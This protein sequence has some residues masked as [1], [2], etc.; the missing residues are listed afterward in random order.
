MPSARHFLRMLRD[1][2]GP[3]TSALSE[4]PCDDG[5]VPFVVAPGSSSASDVVPLGLPKEILESE[6]VNTLK[7][8][9]FGSSDW[10]GMKD[11]IW[12]EHPLYWIAYKTDKGKQMPHVK[13]IG[14]V[15]GRGPFE[16]AITGSRWTRARFNDATELIVEDN[17]R[18]SRP[19]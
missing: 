16:D 9:D 6:I 19:R 18:V 7:N 15:A 17:Y 2:P 4:P 12:E 10:K 8:V 13:K 1:V 11:T 5:P 14:A 3:V